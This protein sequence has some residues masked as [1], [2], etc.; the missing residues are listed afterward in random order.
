MRDPTS[1]G[2]GYC[3][4]L[5]AL[6]G[7]PNV[8]PQSGGLIG[9]PQIGQRFDLK[10]RQTERVLHGPHGEGVVRWFAD[11]PATHVNT[12]DEIIRL[13]KLDVSEARRQARMGHARPTW[14]VTGGQVI[15]PSPQRSAP[16][17]RRR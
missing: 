13:H 15:G 7:D 10:Q 3:G 6:Y 16:P 11:I 5:A 12:A 2:T 9:Y 14:D 4:S 17:P 1:Y 8:N